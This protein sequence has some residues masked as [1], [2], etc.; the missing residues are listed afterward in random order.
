[1]LRMWREGGHVKEKHEEGSWTRLPEYLANKEKE[2][3]R[4]QGIGL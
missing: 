3:D 1:M 4:C 2:R